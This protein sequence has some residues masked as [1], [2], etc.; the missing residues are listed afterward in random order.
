MSRLAIYTCQ[1]AS[2]FPEAQA[3]TEGPGWPCTSWEC[4]LLQGQPHSHKVQ[5]STTVTYFHYFIWE[6]LLLFHSTS[7]H[8]TTSPVIVSEH[9][10]MRHKQTTNKDVMWLPLPFHFPKAMFALFILQFH[11]AFSIHGR[12]HKTYLF[13]CN[14]LSHNE[15][16]EV[17]SAIW[18]FYFSRLRKQSELI[19]LR[20]MEVRFYFALLYK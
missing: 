12:L 11:V 3:Q 15:P 7:A 5:G 1:A 13:V 16:I 2:A 19:L 10:P 4:C 8:Y 6:E 9:F 14:N 18:Y 17:S 20:T